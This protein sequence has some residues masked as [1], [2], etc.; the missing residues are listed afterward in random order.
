M[1]RCF[2]SI[3][4]SKAEVRFKI[5]SIKLDPTKPGGLIISFFVAIGKF[6]S[7]GFVIRP[8]QGAISIKDSEYKF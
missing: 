8:D 2:F 5:V 3:R 1:S 6:M 7:E 4:R